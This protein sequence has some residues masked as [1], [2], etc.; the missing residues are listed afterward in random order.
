MKNQN[1]L[2]IDGQHVDL[3]KMKINE[4][5][6]MNL[7]SGVFI[8]EKNKKGHTVRKIDERCRDAEYLGHGHFEFKGA[9]KMIPVESMKATSLEDLLAK[10]EIFGTVEFTSGNNIYRIGKI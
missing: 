6:K 7:S 8:V 2:I 9:G 4:E 3:P 1:W 5:I 10:V